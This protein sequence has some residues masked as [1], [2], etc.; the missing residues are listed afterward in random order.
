MTVFANLRNQ[1]DMTMLTCQFNPSTVKLSK[2]AGW[3]TPPARNARDHPRPQFVGTGPQTLTLSLLFNAYGRDGGAAALPVAT[4]V[5]KLLD[6]TQ[7]TQRS[8]EAHRPEPPTIEFRWGAHVT[9]TGFLKSVEV[10]YL[11]FDNDGTPLRASANV[12]LQALPQ[13]TP[14]TN[15]TSGGISGRRGAQITQ[16]DS[17]ASIAQREY[18]DAN[19][20]RAIAIANDIDDPGRVPP[21]TGLLLPPRAQAAALAAVGGDPR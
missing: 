7:P 12:Q 16:G 4:T 17:L 10:E 9:M 14:G 21:G 3:S 11:L 20:W 6:W 13:P 18:G 5:Q 2:S 1:D 19:L 8:Q 15:P